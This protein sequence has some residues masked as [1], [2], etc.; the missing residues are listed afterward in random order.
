[1]SLPVQ[2]GLSLTALRALLPAGAGLSSAPS[3]VVLHYFLP[4]VGLFL[5]FHCR[6]LY[7]EVAAQGIR[8]PLI[9]QGIF[10]ACFWRKIQD[11]A[12]FSADGMLYIQENSPFLV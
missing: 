1:M 6:C 9:I 8:H 10:L 5:L 3:S 7:N 4:L 11:A 12:C 2:V